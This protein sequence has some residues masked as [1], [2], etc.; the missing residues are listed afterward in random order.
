MEHPYVVA[1]HTPGDTTIPIGLPIRAWI[2][3]QTTIHSRANWVPSASDT[4]SERHGRKTAATQTYYTRQN[5]ERERERKK[6]QSGAIADSEGPTDSALSIAGNVVGILTFALGVFSFCVAF[7]TI[8][9]DAHREIQD[10]KDAFEGGK[11]HVEE[12]GRYFEDLDI[13]ADVDFEHSCIKPIV[14]NSLWSLKRRHR[15]LE[16]ELGDIRGRLQWWYRRKDITSSL[17]VIK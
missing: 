3:P 7:Y 16:T 15:E 17:A 4:T 11:S 2:G 14:A 1:M 10:L 5:R 8:T 9:Y 6:Q 13:A 12:L